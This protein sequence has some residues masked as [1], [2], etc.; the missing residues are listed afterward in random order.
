[1][2]K[3]SL[4]KILQEKGIAF[5]DTDS[6]PSLLKKV[7]DPP[8]RSNSSSPGSQAFSDSELEPYAEL[9]S[10][11][12]LNP[13]KDKTELSAAAIGHKNEAL[14]IKS[15]CE[16]CLRNEDD[17]NSDDNASEF[18]NFSGISIYQPGLVQKKGSKFVKG[19]ADGILA[20]KVRSSV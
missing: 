19:S 3:A 20:A 6:K 12:F 1:M 2:Q 7:F 11:S 18:E 5:R 9:L 4:K 16:A 15:F 8:S 13:L 10:Q 17:D 14:F